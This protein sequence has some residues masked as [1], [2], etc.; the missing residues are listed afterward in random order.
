M[1]RI[2]TDGAYRKL[3][4]SAGAGVL[5]IWEDG[6]LSSYC[7]YL[8]DTTNNRAE[9]Q[10]I[11]YGLTIALI[12]TGGSTPVKVLSDSTYALGIAGNTMKAKANKELAEETRAIVSEFSDIKFVWVKGHSKDRYNRLAD[13]LANVAIDQHLGLDTKY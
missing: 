11:K 4:D 6:K 1:I 3:L 5:I 10:A 12:E 2:Y 7:K 8:G 13:L 9:L